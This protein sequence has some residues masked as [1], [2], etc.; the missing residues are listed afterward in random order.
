VVILLNPKSANYGFRVP[1]SIL[2]LGAF[3]EGKHKYEIVDQNLDRNVIRTLAEL[4]RNNN[5]EY[6]GITVMPGLQLQ[7]AIAISKRM[8]Q[9][10]PHL[11]IIWGGYFP[12]LHPNT[13]LSSDYVDFVF[14]GR[15]EHSLPEFLST[16]SARGLAPLSEMSSLSA[17]GLAPLSEMSSLS[18]RGLAPLT[19]GKD[20]KQGGK[21]PCT[22]PLKPPCSAIMGL[23]YRLNGKIIHNPPQIQIDPNEIPTL[24]YHKIDMEK[25]LRIAATYLGPRTM[26][27][28]SSIGCPFLCGFCAVAGLYKGKWLGRDPQLV[29]QDLKFVKDKYGIGAVEFHDDNFFV[30]EQRTYEIAKR[31]SEL[32]VGWWGEARPDTVMK[33]SDETFRMMKDSGLKMV[34]FGAES[35]SEET[36]KLMSKGG[37][38]TPQTVLDLAE[39]CKRFGI[40]PEFSFVLGSPS[41]DPDRDIE[42]DILYIRKLKRINPHAEI[43][44]YIYTP[45][46][47]EDSEMSLAAKM[48]GFEYPGTLDD[49][50]LPRW[51]YFD[52]RKNPHTPWLKPHHIRKILNFEKTLNACYP[53]VSDTK[54][55]GWRRS[56]LRTLG[57]WRYMSSIYSSPYEIKLAMKLLR[58]R[59]PEVEGFAFE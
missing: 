22:N 34:F 57:R 56:M 37:K 12:S 33:Y 29:Y 31:I 35:S 28:V 40:I 17:R 59:Q 7:N 11:K 20:D 14:R 49:W 36:L 26:G 48:K 52:H 21:P 23:S 39:R 38:Q 32:N 19:Q 30:S 3:L 58:Y 42:R 43:I 10:V 50:L 46:N 4:L 27:Y 24:P 1:N 45:V 15:C 2:T 44:I 51:K 6:L 16:F 41:D 5:T 18:A 54:I 8:K 9:L 47:Y 53:T 13:V 55:R 25:Y